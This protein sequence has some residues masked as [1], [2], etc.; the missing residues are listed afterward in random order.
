[1]F[2]NLA[3]GI[4]ASFILFSN[5]LAKTAPD[6]HMWLED[7]DGT[8]ALAWVRATNLKTEKSLASLRL[9]N[10]IYTDT[11]KAL[12]SKDK[13]PEITLRGNYVYSLYQDS[14]HPRGVYRRALLS[15]FNAGK[16][17][18][19]SVLDIDALS[20]RDGVKWVF[21]GMDCYEPENKKCLV[22]LSPGG[23]DAHELKEFNLVTRRFVTDG[24]KLP[25]SKMT[26]TWMDQD[27]LFVATEFG[28][29][30]MTESGYPRIVKIW[31][32][33]TRLKNAPILKQTD[34]KSVSIY[35]NRYKYS[36]GEIDIIIERISYWSN[37]YYQ[38]IEDKITRLNIPVSAVL[39][40][41][42]KGQ[43]VITLQRDW[44]FNNRNYKH[45]SVLL[46][47]PKSVQ[48]QNGIA[49]SS[50][51]PTVLI[52]SSPS[53]VVESVTVNKESILIVVLEDVK[54]KIYRFREGEQD[55]VKEVIGLPT[56]GQIVVE[57]SNDSTGVF[58]ARYEDFL[59]PPTLYA[60]DN[61]L[62]VEVALQQSSTFNSRDMKVEQYFTK[63]MDGTRVPYFAIMKKGTL[64]DGSNPTHMF[65]YG[66]FR[67]SLTP[68]YSGSYEKHNGAYGKAWLERGGV[69]VVANI[70][71]G[72]EYGPA[73]HAAALLENRNKA[74]E[75]LEA[76]A[77]DLIERKITSPKHLGVEGRSNGG[78]LVGATMIRRPDLYGAIVC[79]MPLLDMQRY[80]KL[81]AGSSWMAEYGDPS[82]DDWNF[83]SLYSP[84]QLLDISE[85]YPPV[86][87]YSSTRDDRVHPG[88]ARKMAAKMMAQGHKIDYFENT[89]GG[90][91]GSATNEQL[92]KR[93]ALSY[94]HLWTHLNKG[95]GEHIQ[96]QQDTVQPLE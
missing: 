35:A 52:K 10:E 96:E 34:R 7:V 12:D 26:V 41:V 20:K 36:Q 43:L 82:T 31:K 6:R 4:L 39:N 49:E 65:A 40:D 88:H 18:W 85:D 80:H 62:N 66:G 84:Y 67:A 2:R 60:V 86:F 23:G 9:Y 57:T 64:Y 54:S 81:L 27:H 75:D 78:L 19:E 74:F 16:P 15:R 5:S 25:K 44:N 83:M 93:I 3:V 50:H 95:V 8:N 21:K 55:W 61:A 71:G 92:A 1:M 63:S 68:S 56:S 38:R 89:E 42:I 59:T 79:G 30:S 24:F 53:A 29:G 47:D 33:G 17:I 46:V 87:F 14:K 77:E 90:H 32:R 76:V 70:R 73:W 45:G 69:Y 51:H 37:R 91:K 94:T 11:L 48:D 58:Y 72:G 22:K 28:R 13:L